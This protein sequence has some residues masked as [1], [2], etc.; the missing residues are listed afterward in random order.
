MR[1]LL[2]IIITTSFISVQAQTQFPAAGMGNYTQQ[3]AFNHYTIL[4]DSN[5]LQKKWSVSTYGGIGAGIG[6]FNG[7]NSSFFPAQIGLQINRRLNNH[8]YA[9]AGVAVTPV[10]FNFNHS[11]SAAEPHGNYMTAPGFNTNRFGIY[12]G[13]QAGLMYV[14]DAKTFSISG[15][16]GISNNNYPY[17]PSNRINTQKQS[18]FTGVRP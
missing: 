5:G 13:I 14:N 4:N 1:I 2:L 12:Q 8:L 16:I 17:F 10:F 6:F 3:G 11:F 18:T 7:G 9:F 15:S